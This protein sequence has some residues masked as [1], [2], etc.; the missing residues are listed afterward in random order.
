M[1]KLIPIL[2]L[3]VFSITLSA[4]DANTVDLSTL[5]DSS[6]DSSIISEIDDEALEAT[7]YENTVTEDSDYGSSGALQATDYTLEDMLLY[8]IQDEYAAR[9]EYDYILQ[10]FDVTKPFSNIIESE[11]QHI[12][13]L[14]PLFETY[15]IE[16]PEDTS[17][18]HLLSID[19]LEETF[20]IGVIAEINNIAMY[21]LFL[22]TEDLPDDVYD[23]FVKL[24]D[25]SINHLAAFQKNAAKYE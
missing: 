9:S 1:N 12:S 4:C 20:S 16:L 25:A 10:T 15:G 23:V 13:M 5:E 24:R 8:A 21:N 14:L 6:I 11:E 7:I 19:S 22:E 18:E 17:F 3:F 2:L